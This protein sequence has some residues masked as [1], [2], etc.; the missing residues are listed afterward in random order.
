MFFNLLVFWVP[1]DL[2]LNCPLVPWVPPA[3]RGMLERGPISGFCR[4]E[5]RIRIRKG[6]A[7]HG[8]NSPAT[9]RHR[10]SPA[11]GTASI[12]SGWPW[13]RMEHFQRRWNL[14]RP[15]AAS[16]EEPTCFQGFLSLITQSNLNKFLWDWHILS[17]GESFLLSFILCSEA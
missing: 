2:V 3:P 7:G 17:T 14:P 4:V 16:S 1:L 15:W 13:D 12:V 6:R 5:L 10:E 11:E 8:Q 9:P